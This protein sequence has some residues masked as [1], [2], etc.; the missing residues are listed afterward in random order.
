MQTHI[1]L[2]NQN[3]FGFLN[4]NTVPL[5]TME[6][7][8]QNNERKLFLPKILYPVKVLSGRLILR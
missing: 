8:F 1:I 5:K 4:S 6:Q 3:D 2:Q 7:G